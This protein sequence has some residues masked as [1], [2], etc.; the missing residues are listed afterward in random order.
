MAKWLFNMKF[1][2][3]KPFFTHLATAKPKICL[4]LTKE[5]A[6][7]K[8]LLSSFTGE[9]LKFSAEKITEATYLQEIQSLSLFGGERLL[10]IQDIELAKEPLKKAIIES[11]P[12]S[13][14]GLVRLFTAGSLASNTLLY[15]AIDKAGV[16]LDLSFEKP[17][18]K[19]EGLRNYLLAKE[20][21]ME[22]AALQELLTRT[23]GDFSAVEQE[24]EKLLCYTAGKERI[25]LQDV[26]S[27]TINYALPTV[28]KLIDALFSRDSRTTLTLGRTLLQEA[29][30]IFPLIRLLRKQFETGYQI[31]EM[32][33]RGVQPEEIAALFPTA[34]KLLTQAKNF[35]ENRFKKGVIMLDQLEVN[36][37]NSGGREEVLWEQLLI[38]I[39]Q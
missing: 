34:K 19:E 26:Q 7:L 15:K 13:I 12:L 10:L 14:P 31:A 37:K 6:L 29:D 33:K 32:Q 22:P 8:L 3:Q 23:A 16:I 39:V 38:Q 24:Y 25:T 2:Q 20:K 36:M 18:E 21:K 4:L 27:L 35:G 17:W 28:W 9:L 30:S 1:T 5:P 11:I